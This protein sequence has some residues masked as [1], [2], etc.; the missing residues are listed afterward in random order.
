MRVEHFVGLPVAPSVHHFTF[1]PRLDR[2]ATQLLVAADGYDGV[3]VHLESV[4]R[5]H[6]ALGGRPGAHRDPGAAGS[7]AAIIAATIASGL[8][9]VPSVTVSI[10]RSATA[11]KR[12]ARRASSSATALA[13]PS[14]RR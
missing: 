6:Q 5:R 9:V 7:T 14:C 1:G 4:H 8:V 12:S 2:G 3:R 13:S 10:V 11:P